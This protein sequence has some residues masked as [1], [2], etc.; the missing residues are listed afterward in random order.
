[1]YKTIKK[2]NRRNSFFPARRNEHHASGILR[3]IQK[4]N[5]CLPVALKPVPT[6]YFYDDKSQNI[7]LIA[8]NIALGSDSVSPFNPLFELTVLFEYFVL[9]KLHK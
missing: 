7:T 6:K 5:I 1:M 9:N 4:Q 2:I 8:A 3:Q